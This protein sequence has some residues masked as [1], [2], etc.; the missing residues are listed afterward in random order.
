MKIYLVQ[1]NDDGRGNPFVGYFA[2]K[3]EATRALRQA[4]KN[5]FEDEQAELRER[6]DRTEDYDADAHIVEGIKEQIGGRPRKI[7]AGEITKLE[8]KGKHSMVNALN[9]AISCGGTAAGGFDA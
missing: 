1:E 5:R 9:V 3:I 2:T 7:Q 8:I 6:L 4:I